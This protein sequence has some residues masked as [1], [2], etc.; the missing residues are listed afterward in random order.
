MRTQTVTLGRYRSAVW[1]ERK[2]DFL[3]ISSFGTWAL[4]LGLTPLAV[5]ALL[6]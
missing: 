2:Q 6:S 5:R 3:L 4:I 1:D